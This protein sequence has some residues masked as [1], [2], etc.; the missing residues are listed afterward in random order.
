MTA[1]AKQPGSAGVAT[2]PYAFF[3]IVAVLKIP[4]DVATNDPS[5]RTKFGDWYFPVSTRSD[6]SG[7]YVEQRGFESSLDD[8]VAFQPAPRSTSL[9]EAAFAR[10]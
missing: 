6:W 5:V 8:G 1:P 2:R 7:L 4:V 10:A 3:A 9:S